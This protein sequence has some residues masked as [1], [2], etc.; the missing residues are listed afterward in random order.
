MEHLDHSL[1]FSTEVGPF[2]LSFSATKQNA[3]K[4]VGKCFH[5]SYYYTF[6]FP[7]LK[8][9]QQTTLRKVQAEFLIENKEPQQ[10]YY[11]KIYL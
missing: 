2:W 8:K 5:L 9:Q 1:T 7:F 3:R 10:Q 6:P 4:Q 11:K